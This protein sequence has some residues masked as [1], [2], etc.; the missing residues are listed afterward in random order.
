M[1][2]NKKKFSKNR[3][4]QKNKIYEKGNGYNF[5]LLFIKKNV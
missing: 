1:C 4:R 5:S 2:K 3:M